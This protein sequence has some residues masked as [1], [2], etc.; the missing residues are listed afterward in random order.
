MKKPLPNWNIWLKMPSLTAHQAVCLS[1]DLDPTKVQ[2]VK[3]YGDIR[4]VW[5]SKHLVLR[6]FHCDFFLHAY[7][8]IQFPTMKQNLGL[9]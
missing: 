7:S 3:G 5:T 6:Q 1:L 2:A 8:H 4:W 9:S